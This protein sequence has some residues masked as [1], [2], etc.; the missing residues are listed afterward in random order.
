V[1]DKL[2]PED[3]DLVLDVTGH[4]DSD[5]VIALGLHFRRDE[6]KRLYKVDVWPRH[7]KIPIDLGAFFQYIGDQAAAQ[8][9]LKPKHLKGILRIQS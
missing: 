8:L 2:F 9:R 5:L 6:L 7:P 3:I 1:R 4:S